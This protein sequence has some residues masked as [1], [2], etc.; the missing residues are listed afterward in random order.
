MS[1]TRGYS[2]TDRYTASS[3]TVFL[4]GVQALARVV[5]DQLRRDASAGRNVDAFVSG[6]PG[7]PLAGL[8][9]EFR[10]AA[11]LAPDV[12]VIHR[13][14][15]NEELAAT[16][17]MGSQLAGGR[18]DARTE[19]V[20]GIWYGK[21]PGLDRASDALRHAVFAGASPLGGAL[22]VVGDD[23]AAKS[24]TLPSSSDTALIDLRMP[25]LY[26]GTVA[27]I[28]ELGLH[29]VALSRA[30]GL[31]TALKVVTPVADAT[32]TVGLPI[33]V[34]P[35]VPASERDGDGSVHQPSAMFLGEP[36]L[37]VE[38]RL[39]DVRLDRARQYIADNR[40]NEVTVDPP[41]AWLGCVAAGFTYYELLEA[42]R[43]LGFENAAAIR[44]AGVRLLHLKAP[45]PFDSGRVVDF[46]RGL[47]EILVV[48]EKNPTLEGLVRDA[49]Y[50]TSMRPP[51]TGKFAPD[52]ARLLPSHGLLDADAI[53]PALRSR[54]ATRLADRLP[55]IATRRLLPLSITRAPYFCSGCPHNS[56]TAVPSGALVG[57]GIG[58][59]GMA[60]L[61]DPDRVGETVGVSA[62]GTEGSTW[63]GM[64]PF[65]DT[66][67]IFQN[68]GDGTFLH[69]GQLAIQ[70]AVAAQANVT[71]KLL[72]NSTVAMTGGQS[73]PNAIAL[74]EMVR[75]LR[76]MGVARIV[77][78]TDHPGGRARSDL[79]PGTEVRDRRDI[80]A[81]QQDLAATAGVTVLIHDQACA[82]ELRRARKRHLAETP[83]FRVVINHRICEGCGDCG[84]V[85]NCLSVQPV[86][87][88][89]GRKTRIDQETC[90]LDASCLDGDCPAFMTVLPDEA[91][92][93][94][95]AHTA[96][97]VPEPTVSCPDGAAIVLAGIGGTG[98]VTTAQLIGTAAMLD[99]MHVDG[100]DQ[101]G[102]AQ[103]AGPVISGVRLW[104]AGDERQAKLIGRA[105]ADVLLALDQ[106]VAAEPKTVA[107]VKPVG[108]TIL[109]S[110]STTPTGVQI[111]N[112]SMVGPSPDELRARL[113]GAA[114]SY[115][116]VD[117]RRFV[118]ELTRAPASANLFLVGAA[119]QRG[120]V[121]ISPA[122]M[123]AAIRL[124]GVAVDD[125]IAAFE[126]GRRWAHEPDAVAAL[127]AA[128]APDRVAV[129]V[130]ELP[131]ALSSQIDRL[132]VGGSSRAVV[133]MLA[134][135]LVGYQGPRLARRFVEFAGTVAADA[136]VAALVP[137][138][139]DALVDAGCRGYHKLLA[140]KDEYEV[141]RLMT[142]PDGLAEARSIAG[143]DGTI[144][145][146]LHPPFLRALGMK[147]KIS[148]G[149]RWRPLFRLLAWGR[150]VRGT[151]LDLFG[152]ASLRRLERSL[153]PEY[154]TAMLAAL[155]ALGDATYDA[156]LSLAGLPDMVRGF[157][158]VKERNVA[159]Y[160]A[161]LASALAALGGGAPCG[162]R[163]LGTAR[164]SE[165]S[166]E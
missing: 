92:V 96:S 87:T 143:P 165:E 95:P 161:A 12:R 109:A 73:S 126:W 22:A 64:A 127:V 156:V 66:S 45:W 88:P 59:H 85:S 151:P 125:N 139:R 55:Q 5:I 63:L 34:V 134:A 9:G 98:V 75:M 108:G 140:Y 25:I 37:E 53:V 65:V 44:A 137:E 52:G 21:A 33:E 26:P 51:V 10:R 56:S 94:A 36:L 89:F 116:E 105:Q 1:V 23:P 28:I 100:L 123:R 31:W 162:D 48:E 7:S 145:W 32:E 142:S 83:P 91:S 138:R 141:A 148:F 14:A 113:A 20:V 158:T 40:L 81:V 93:P 131:A 29:G 106:L 128:R 163:T 77:V 135:D 39:H 57:M 71:F 80:V 49:L 3:G 18:P 101:T 47:D 152:L 129:T 42:F 122:S 8:D 78:T 84:R 119:V 16:A 146:R 41:D 149:Q 46:A 60:L 132:D 144:R 115:H 166:R 27:E 24:S 50:P 69:S 112:P 147:R 160:R 67:H 15:V 72:Y 155:D 154:R 99:G 4:S 124:N 102:L 61:M 54:L 121:P 97:S 76:A 136:R 82:T 111:T 110:T 118:T 103:K 153:A 117:A 38:R 13:A 68:L 74:P 17:V 130:P 11:A 6:Y 19:G 58:C 133:A 2:L 157:E 104:R 120:V 164:R 150:R 114:D 159:E 90:N 79:P 43:R 86:A 62:M 70:A 35:R 30:S 107:L